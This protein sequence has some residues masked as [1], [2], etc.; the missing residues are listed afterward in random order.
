M[1]Q[2]KII[3]DYLKNQK[4]L[5]KQYNKA[6]KSMGVSC[7]EFTNQMQNLVQ[8]LNRS[9]PAQMLED[10]KFQ[11]IYRSFSRMWMTPVAATVGSMATPIINHFFMVKT[12]PSLWITPIICVIGIAWSF[13]FIFRITRINQSFRSKIAI[14]KKLPEYTFI[15]LACVAWLVSFPWLIILHH[16]ISRLKK[17]SFV[18]EIMES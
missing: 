3:Q 12:N 11:R 2:E 1:N 5:T 17:E 16:R 9:F 6:L 14:I 7:T 4:L 13:S 18:A 15:M 8:I 10:L